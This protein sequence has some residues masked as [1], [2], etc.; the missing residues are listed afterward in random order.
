MTPDRTDTTEGLREK[1]A[2][3]LEMQYGSF[4][5]QDPYDPAMF[6]DR[7]VEALMPFIDSHR[8]KVIA[9]AEQRGREDNADH[10]MCYVHGSAALAALIAAEVARERTA[11]AE[12]IA[13]AWD[14]DTTL[15]AAIEGRMLS[16][17]GRDADA[18][19]DIGTMWLR[20]YLGQGPH[21]D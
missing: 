13:R 15:Y 1:L 10:G 3:A 9:E 14:S 20:N 19:Q 16:S 8:D 7:A 5:A 12:E 6:Y 2:W 4:L 21:D 17:E 18:V 11:V